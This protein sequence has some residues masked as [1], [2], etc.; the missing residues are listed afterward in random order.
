MKFIEFLDSCKPKTC[1]N[2]INIVIKN[3]DVGFVYGEFTLY[4][5][6]TDY[7]YEDIFADELLNKDVHTFTAIADNNFEV[8]I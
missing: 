3:G 7:D 4:V 5:G 6:L 1:S 8:V 2:I